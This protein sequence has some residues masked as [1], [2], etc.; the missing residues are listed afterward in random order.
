M[1]KQVREP[2]L[3]IEMFVDEHDTKEPSDADK[4]EC[5][6]RNVEGLMK[7]PSRLAWTTPKLS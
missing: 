5:L 2:L 6:P 3:K 7:K 4:P 1:D